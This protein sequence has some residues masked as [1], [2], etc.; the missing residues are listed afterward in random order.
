MNSFWEDKYSKGHQQL[1]PWDIVVSFLLQSAPE[2]HLRRNINILEVGCGTGSNLWF[3]AREGFSVTGIDIS[4]SALQRARQRFQQDKLDVDLC[5]ATFNAIPFQSEYFDYVIDR[6][7]LCCVDE[8]Q[9]RK[10]I[11]ELNRVLKK[12]GRFLFNAYADDHSS[13]KYGDRK[14]NKLVGN[15]CKGTLVGAG[16]LRPTSYDDIQDIFNTEWK[17]ISVEKMTRTDYQYDNM[18]MHSEWLVISEK[19]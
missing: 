18:M 6:E 1:Y 15:I 4:I 10:S 8:I 12:G 9:F 13:F 19:I 5:L 11:C 17:C 14:K 2:K 3:A 7:A 16:D